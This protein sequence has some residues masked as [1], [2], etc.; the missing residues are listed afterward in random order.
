M[1]VRKSVGRARQPRPRN[2]LF[3]VAILMTI[4]T[5]VVAPILLVPAF[6]R[7]GSGLRR[8]EVSASGD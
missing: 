6:E 7:G 5:T 1:K 3:G 4:V 2:V 8:P